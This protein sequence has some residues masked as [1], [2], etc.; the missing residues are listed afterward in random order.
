MSVLM[1]CSCIRNV[2]CMQMHFTNWHFTYFTVLQH[3]SVLLNDFPTRLFGPHIT[4]RLYSVYWSTECISPS[5]RVY[6][7]KLQLYYSC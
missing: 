6:S 1:Q 3:S 4:L 5:H 2:Y 7:A